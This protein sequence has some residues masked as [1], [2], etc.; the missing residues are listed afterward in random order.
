MRPKIQ[1][2]GNMCFRRLDVTNDGVIDD[3]SHFVFGSKRTTQPSVTP[4]GHNFGK[5]TEDIKREVTKNI[6]SIDALEAEDDSEV[7][8]ERVKNQIEIVDISGQRN[9][10]E[11]QMK[12]AKYF[13]KFIIG[14]GGRQR[15]EVED[16]TGTRISV[17]SENDLTSPLVITGNNKDDIKYAIKKIEAIIERSRSRSDFTHFVSIPLNHE[18]IRER[19]IE[20]KNQVMK[21]NDSNSNNI[22]EQLFQN[23]RILH[24]TVIPLLL[25]DQNERTIASDILQDCY[26]NFIRP[27]TSGQQIRVKVE[28]IDCMNDDPKQVNVLYAKVHDISDQPFLQPIAN[29]VFERFKKSGLCAGKLHDLD[30]MNT[31]SKVKIHM[32]IMNTKFLDSDDKPSVRGR[33]RR[34]AHR[35]CF[36]ASQ[37]I[38][39]FD[40]YCFGETTVQTI[41]I[42]VRHSTQGK[43]K[44]YS[45]TYRIEL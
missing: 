27:L 10:F 15:R 25:T 39:N 31:D 36:D 18:L 7:T 2:I 19:F 32:T 26:D 11:A 16:M 28:G 33:G 13:H 22:D 12:I 40:N 9:R 37:I 35:Q 20:F 5:D 3:L 45:H 29:H 24:L 43:D 41:E 6:P 17:P 38:K 42:S 1:R 14:Q 4:I 44:Y 34:T 21:M 8:D 30:R 23:S